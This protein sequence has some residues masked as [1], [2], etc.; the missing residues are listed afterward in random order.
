MPPIN[1]EQEENP[2]RR[3]KTKKAG[4]ADWALT[5]IKATSPDLFKAKKPIITSIETPAII[6]RLFPF[7]LFITNPLLL[8]ILNNGLSFLSTGLSKKL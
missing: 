8:L 2:A 1:A 5:L 6:K 3:P 4:S 7:S